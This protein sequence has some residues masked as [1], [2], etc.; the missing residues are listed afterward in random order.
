ML[1]DKTDTDPASTM[2]I[3]VDGTDQLIN[4]LPQFREISDIPTLPADVWGHSIG[5]FLHTNQRCRLACCSRKLA[6]ILQPLVRWHDVW[7]I[8]VDSQMLDENRD[9]LTLSLVSKNVA[10]AR[11]LVVGNRPPFV[12]PMVF[13][14]HD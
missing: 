7:Q 6:S 12:F 10:E 3:A 1:M 9:E 14:F 11:T 4:G 2:L 8:V 5:Q 13:R